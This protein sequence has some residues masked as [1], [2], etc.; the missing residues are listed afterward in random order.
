MKDFMLIFVGTNYETMDLS[1]E[2][3]QER[4]GKWWT[5]QE[6]ME[7]AG[8]LKSGHA[9]HSHGKH[10]TGPQRVVTDKTSTELKELVGGYYIVKAKDYEGAIEISQDY[11]DYDLGGRVEIREVIV[12]DK[13]S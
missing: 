1:P 13:P 12:F 11:P 5:W 3:M 2:E 4:M 9:L 10:V 6:K 8:Q 7:A